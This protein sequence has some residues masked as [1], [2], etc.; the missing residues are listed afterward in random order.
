MAR[1]SSLVET[2][3]VAGLVATLAGLA[4]PATRA[5][6]YDARAGSAARYVAAQ[7][8][9]ARMTAVLS[10]NAVGFRFERDEGGY[11]FARFRDGNGNGIRQT[12][13]RRGT[14][15]QAGPVDRLPARAPGVDFGV[16][17][18]VRGVSGR[19][20][21]RGGDDPL[22]IGSADIL[23][24]T[25]LGTATSG[26]LYIRGQGARQY[27]VRIL[28]GTGRVR[29]LEYRFASSTWVER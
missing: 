8:R 3:F 13:I 25:A 15:T 9:L 11:R 6:V 23:T 20:P 17:D 28:G 7:L 4:V 29:I 12:D 18:G 14:D 5:T 26:T 19:T 27:A 24:F 10:Q 21:L 1:G 2:V 16:V 22:R